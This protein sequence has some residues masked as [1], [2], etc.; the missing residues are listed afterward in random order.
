MKKSNFGF[1]TINTYNK[2]RK[3]D[4]L[5]YKNSVNFVVIGDKNLLKILS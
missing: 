3:I 1:N 5:A 2:I 4:N